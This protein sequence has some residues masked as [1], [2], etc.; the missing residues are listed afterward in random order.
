MT[1]K[2][3]FIAF[4]FLSLNVWSQPGSSDLTTQS[5]KAARYYQRALNALDTRYLDKAILELNEAI[6]EDPNFVE[7]YIVMG[8]TY[9]RMKNCSKAVEYYQKAN[10]INAEFYP[11]L[12]YLLAIQQMDCGMYREALPNF[13]KSMHIKGNNVN[14]MKMVQIYINRCEFAV[15][16]MNSPVKFNPQNFG[17]Y[18]NSSW[19]EYLPTIT[20]DEETFIFTVRRPKDQYTICAGCTH[21]EDFYISQKDENGLWM[22]RR[23]LGKPVN[24]HYNE[25]AQSISPDGK[26]LVFTG[27]NRPD[28]QGSCDLYW[29]K[30]IGKIWTTP[31]NIGRPVNTSYWES[32]PSFAADGKTIYFTSN[33]AGGLGGTDIWKTTMIKEG[34]FTEPENIGTP[35]NTQYNEVS[36]FIHS[37]G[38]TLYFSSDGH[39]GMGGKDLFLSRMDTLNNWTE[40]V[41]LGYPINTLDDEVNLIVNSKGNIAYYSSDKPGGFGGLDIYWFELDESIRP[42]SVTYFKGKVFE[43]LTNKPLEANIELI[44][45]HTGDT[46]TIIKSDAQTGEFLVCIPTDNEYSLNVN[47]ENF[48]FYSDNFNLTGIYSKTE[49]FKKDIPLKSMRIGEV[50]VLKNVFFDTD[51]YDLKQES[52]I[53][54]NKVVNL[55]VQNKNIQIEIGGHTDNQ[56]SREHN[57]TLS[58]NRAQSVFDYLVLKGIDKSRLSYK[59][60]GMDVPIADNESFEGRAINRR[61]EF[62]IVAF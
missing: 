50:V 57:K 36:P 27:C 52:I 7:A 28:G 22:P 11:S 38:R 44:N 14:H 55:L 33:R 43:E 19:D 20:A 1:K 31:R 60:Y 4:L 9:G 10:E 45:I 16:L 13:E 41:N 2:I 29:S 37:D 54:L 46:V 24:T 23:P 47:N 49:P 5:K 48:L 59:G 32:Q 58:N 15:N 25:G 56:G 12:V 26:Y 17:E 39:K 53:E 8:D 6:N 35:I 34:V 21:E 30:K 51:K 61:T 40:P 62:K 42:T 3:L 18:I